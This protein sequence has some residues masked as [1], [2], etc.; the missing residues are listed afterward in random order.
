LVRGDLL[1]KLGRDAEAR[2]E[3][4]RAASLTQNTRQRAVLLQRMAASSARNGA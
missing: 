3:F 1:I 2:R 4:E